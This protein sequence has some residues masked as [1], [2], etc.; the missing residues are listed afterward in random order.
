MYGPKSACLLAGEASETERPAA[1]HRVPAGSR[2]R[3]PSQGAAS[4]PAPRPASVW[5]A[6]QRRCRAARRQRYRARAAAAGKRSWRRGSGSDGPNG[7]A[8]AGGL[9]AAR[10]QRRTGDLQPT[11]TRTSRPWSSTPTQR[12]DERRG[13]AP[14]RTGARRFR[15]GETDLPR[16]LDAE[17]QSAV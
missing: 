4:L 9:C 10:P 15:S 6:L 17:E 13:R 1:S 11:E 3:P 8:A 12:R 14:L 16:V 2:S 5:Q 7:A